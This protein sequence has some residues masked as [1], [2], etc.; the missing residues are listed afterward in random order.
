MSRRSRS[1][2]R[3]TYGK[4]QH[5][6]RERRPTQTS[7]ADWSSREDGWIAPELIDDTARREPSYDSY[8]GEGWA[9]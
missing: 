2:R 9:R 1:V 8:D 5:E 3:R 4:R 7:D 6:V